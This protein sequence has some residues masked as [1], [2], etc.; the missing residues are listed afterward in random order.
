MYWY[1]TKSASHIGFGHSATLALSLNKA[2]RII[3]RSILT[4]ENSGGILSFI[5]A[6]FR[7]VKVIPLK[8]FYYQTFL[9]T[10]R[11]EHL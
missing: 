3:N 11:N 6:P 9:E 2:Y 7:Y 10:L 8:L 1:D 5:D 4:D